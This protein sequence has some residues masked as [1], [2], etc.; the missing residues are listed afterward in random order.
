MARWLL[1]GPW[2]TSLLG[3]ENWFNLQ[4]MYNAK[5][6]LYLVSISLAKLN[7]YLF[8]LISKQLVQNNFLTQKQLLFQWKIK[9]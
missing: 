9:T 5:L 6:A 1:I 8:L 3:L 7:L 2:S 4:C